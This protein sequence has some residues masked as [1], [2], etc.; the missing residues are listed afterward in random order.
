MEESLD[1]KL[2]PKSVTRDCR[3]CGFGERKF[4][5]DVFPVVERRH[6]EIVGGKG[7]VSYYV[8]RI[9]TNTAHCP[10]CG[11]VIFIGPTCEKVEAE[12]AAE[13]ERQKQAS[14]KEKQSRSHQQMR[15]LFDRKRSKKRTN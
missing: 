15:E 1:E 7:S 6:S 11:A 4:E 9:H 12:V 5:R 10:N 3:A 14:E 8:R 2:F 13:S